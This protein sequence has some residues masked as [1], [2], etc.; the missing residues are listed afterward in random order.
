MLVNWQ[1]TS[2]SHFLD[3]P[4]ID[5]I[6]TTEGLFSQPQ[7]T[8]AENDFLAFLVE[9]R[10]GWLDFLAGAGY[11]FPSLLYWYTVSLV[12]WTQYSYI[13][14]HSETLKLIEKH[15]KHILQVMAN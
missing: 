10:W 15:D 11:P 2:P 12:R 1:N 13:Y 6:S 4:T 9:L 3:N 7:T 14:K 8:G 5:I